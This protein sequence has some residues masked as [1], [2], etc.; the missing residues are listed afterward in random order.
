MKVAIAVHG[1]FHGFE[2]ASE[3]AA[4]GL[5]AR[6]D[7]T[8]PRFACPTGLPVRSLV[9]LEVIRRSW[10]RLDLPGTPDLFIA[11]RFGHSLATHLPKADILVGWSGASLEAI[12]PAQAAGMKVVL[13]RGSTHM[14]HQSDLLRQAHARFG[15]NWQATDPRLAERELAEYRAVDLICTGSSYARQTFLDQG[16]PPDKIVVNPYGVDLTDFT[17]GQ[18]PRFKRILFAGQ[19]G[20]R[21]GIP[22]LIQAFRALPDDWELHLVGPVEGSMKA[23]FERFDMTRIILRGPL[24]R[25]ALAQEFRQAAIFCLP[26]IEEGF[27]M[28][29][30]QAMASEC[31]VVASTATGGPDAGVHGRELLLVPPG[32]TDSLAQTLGQL[33]NDAS[34]RS[35]LGKA[36]RAR[37]ERGFGWNDYGERAI[38]LYQMLTNP[39]RVC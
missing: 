19:V 24:A 16:I 23:L 36:A 34:L 31:A 12:A 3:L 5:L 28:V 25:A 29:I 11:R 8:Y 35:A 7:T 38:Q 18:N 15:L 10:P 30:L 22:W 26:S 13:E 32:D 2:L 39:K 27:G 33:A 37:V 1:R 9:W 17:P 6:L 21:K 14:T 20:I 4:R